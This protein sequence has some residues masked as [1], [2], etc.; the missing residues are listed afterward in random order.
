MTLAAGVA[1]SAFAGPIVAPTPTPAMTIA[2]VATN[3][4]SWLMRCDAKITP[5][6]RA[7][8]T[9]PKPALTCT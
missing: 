1:A 9:S 4:L 6:R 5:S 8:P 2:A 7:T 3:L